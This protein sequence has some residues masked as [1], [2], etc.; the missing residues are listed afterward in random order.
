MPTASN[1]KKTEISQA[2]LELKRRGRRRLIG[3]ITLGL[4]A[5]VILPMIFD[6]EPKKSASDTNATKQE[7]AIQ[8]PPKEG[9]S[10]LPAPVVP[11]SAP[12]VQT[13]TPPATQP[14]APPVNPPTTVAPP[15]VA[16]V[17]DTPKAEA[18]KATPSPAPS[19]T[20][21]AEPAKP[22]PPKTEPPK[23]EAA[24]AGSFVVQI[25]AYKDADNAKSLVAQLKE[26]KLP[27]FT[28]TVAVK[29]GNVTRVRLGPFTNRDKA[30]SALVQAK[31]IGVTGK[32]VPAQ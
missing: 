17:A 28:D 23:T 9:L 5:A 14:T 21:K 15:P 10:Q 20:P 27:V 1:A 26:A 18:P 22:Q 11:P 24:K 29:T 13:T 6:S 16:K 3:A 7:I 30:E 31:L 8:I 4:L 2:E 12:A 32:V 25:G 19:P